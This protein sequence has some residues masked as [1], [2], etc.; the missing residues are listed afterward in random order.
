MITASTSKATD[1]VQAS[2]A[3]MPLPRKELAAA[4]V[5]PADS[6][7]VTKSSFSASYTTGYPAQ[8]GFKPVTATATFDFGRFGDLPAK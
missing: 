6:D 8:N 7:R 4:L 3:S 2:T 5:A 1:T